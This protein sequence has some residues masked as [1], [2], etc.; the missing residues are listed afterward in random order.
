MNAY[1]MEVL[2]NI[3]ECYMPIFKLIS[4]IKVFPEE[5]G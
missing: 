1:I 5:Y 2:V 4:S 3:I